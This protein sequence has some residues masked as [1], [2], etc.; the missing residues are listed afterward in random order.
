MDGLVHFRQR[1]IPSLKRSSIPSFILK[2][3]FPE[4]YSV[5]AVSF[6]PTKAE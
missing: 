6:N 4:V 2:N 1:A 5:A 3:G